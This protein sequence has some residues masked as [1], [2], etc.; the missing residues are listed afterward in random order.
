MHP[1]PPLE[2]GERIAWRWQTTPSSFTASAV[3]FS[4]LRNRL[5]ALRGVRRTRCGGG[6]SGGSTQDDPAWP[7]TLFS[8]FFPIFVS[9]N[10]PQHHQR[11]RDDKP[12]FQKMFVL[13][14]RTQN[15][16]NDLEGIHDKNGQNDS[17]ELFHNDFSI[18]KRT[19][20]KLDVKLAF[21]LQARTAVMS[22]S[23]RGDGTLGLLLG[24]LAFLSC[25]RS[26]SGAASLS[27]RGW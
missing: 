5:T 6:G 26:E 19:N 22:R 18:F 4:P 16:P 23:R 21:K 17:Q 14:L 1:S 24:N 25:M 15:R 2:P 11:R 7:T 27:L 13:L 10:D 9:A 20:G 8:L 12:D 3:A